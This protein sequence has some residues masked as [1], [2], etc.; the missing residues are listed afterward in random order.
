M[1]IDNKDLVLIRTPD[2]KTVPT[3]RTRI[4][5]ENDGFIVHEFPVDKSWDIG[6]LKAEIKKVFPILQRKAA[7]FTLVKACYGELVH[8]TIIPRA[9][10][11]YEM[12]DSQRGA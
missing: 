1:T 11:G 4:T 8:L 9:R 5:L 10:V 7:N 3:H 12:I 2:C 6:K